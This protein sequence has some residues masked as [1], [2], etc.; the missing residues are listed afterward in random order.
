MLKNNAKKD[1]T[2]Y[3]LWNDSAG[4]W[5]LGKFDLGTSSAFFKKYR[6]NDFG[7]IPKIDE[8][9]CKT[10]W[11]THFPIILK[12]SLMPGDVVPRLVAASPPTTSTASTPPHPSLS[13]EIPP[14]VTGLHRLS[15][16]C[17]QSVEQWATRNSLSA[18]CFDC[19]EQLN[20]WFTI[21]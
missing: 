5:K 6:R 18:P 3:Y 20:V 12:W 1:P 17:A 11:I 4:S 14:F 8:N 2:R 19:H 7:L 15:S 13:S 9:N 10:S 16:S 21:I